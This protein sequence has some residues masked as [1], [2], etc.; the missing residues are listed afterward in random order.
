MKDKTYYYSC[1]DVLMKENILSIL[2]IDLS[3]AFLI[4]ILQ[5]YLKATISIIFDVPS[6]KSTD[7]MLEHFFLH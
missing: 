3:K 6:L 5:C 1:K 4:L 2:L 7:K